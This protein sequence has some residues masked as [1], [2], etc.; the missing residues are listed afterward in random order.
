M[1]QLISRYLLLCN[2]SQK[3]R[4]QVPRSGHCVWKIE[5]REREE[6]TS[7]WN[8]QENILL[9]CRNGGFR[10]LARMK[11]ITGWVQSR[12]VRTECPKTTPIRSTPSSIK[13][14]TVVG[15][16]SGINFQILVSLRL[17]PLRVHSRCQAGS[18]PTIPLLRR[19]PGDL[20]LACCILLGG[21][22]PVR[23]VKGELE[24]LVS[25]SLV[26]NGD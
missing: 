3:P 22:P 14:Y 7:N 4:P 2:N 20:S 11:W 18:L 21:D 23:Q 8:L 16:F 24:I 1:S 25:E 15:N 5:G 10:A 12:K 17:I 19:P 26:H 9:A 6:E 13:E